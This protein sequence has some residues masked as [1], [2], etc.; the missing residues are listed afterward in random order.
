[1][2]SC[3]WASHQTVH[4][5]HV[6]IGWVSTYLLCFIAAGDVPVSSTAD[7]MLS[8][9]TQILQIFTAVVAVCVIVPTLFIVLLIIFCC[10]RRRVL[11][12]R[13]RGLGVPS[14]ENGSHCCDQR[15]WG[16][17]QEAEAIIPKGGHGRVGVQVLVCVCVR[18][19]ICS[20]CVGCHIT[21]TVGTC[22]YICHQCT[23]THTPTA[24]VSLIQTLINAYI[25]SSEYSLSFTF[26]VQP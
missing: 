22:M 23:Y 8:A 7:G 5:I 19:R 17:A 11:Q 2:A 26:T 14:P 3:L 20:V 24:H 15:R 21:H 13:R 4:Y 16:L 12:R 1:M 10:H 9:G 18:A 6:Y 25:T